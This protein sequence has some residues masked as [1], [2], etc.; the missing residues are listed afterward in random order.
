[1]EPECISFSSCSSF[2]WKTH[3][4]ILGLSLGCCPSTINNV[5]SGYFGLHVKIIN[6]SGGPY[7]QHIA[8][9]SW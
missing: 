3:I 2:I 5:I 1:M 9:P 4:I 8:I 7:T 6:R